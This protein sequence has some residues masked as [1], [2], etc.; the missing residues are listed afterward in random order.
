MVYM[1]SAAA[2]PHSAVHN[3]HHTPYSH[4]GFHIAA[5]DQ[6]GDYSAGSR[7]RILHYIPQVELGL[8]LALHIYFC[9]GGGGYKIYHL[10]SALFLVIWTTEGMEK[11][12]E[13]GGG[14]VQNN[15][16]EDKADEEQNPS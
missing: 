11:R 9:D 1:H 15:G 7:S 8:S 2:P 13:N 16:K 4:L 14:D 10:P 3:T 5:V 6:A 12:K